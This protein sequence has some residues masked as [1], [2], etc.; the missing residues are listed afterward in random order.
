MDPKHSVEVPFKLANVPECKK[1]VTCFMEKI[2]VLGNLDSDITYRAVDHK[3][4]VNE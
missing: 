2:H 3:F 1:A 4:N